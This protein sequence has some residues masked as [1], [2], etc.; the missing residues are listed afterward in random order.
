[1]RTR[2][3][4]P[5]DGS[6]PR[7][8]HV[9]LHP[10]GTPTGYLP[11]AA[12]PA[13]WEVHVTWSEE[14]PR[15]W[16]SSV[17]LVNTT[18]K[19]VTPEAWRRVKVGQAIRAARMQVDTLPTLLAFL[20]DGAASVGD[21]ETAGT[22]RRLAGEEA[23]RLARFDGRRPQGAYDEEHYRDVG[24]VYTRLVDRGETQPV[25]QVL[26]EFHE[27][28]GPYADLRESTVKGWIR[29]AKAKG[30][31]TRTARPSRRRTEGGE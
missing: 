18:G 29:T 24:R 12:N 28:G 1:M 30:Y 20:G 26:A 11:S 25:R 3:G 10:D 19:P 27:R 22:A 17:A 8:V 2:N 21:W 23:A 15:M 31:I 14:G 13:E 16:P 5:E 6:E 9:P 4:D 7:T